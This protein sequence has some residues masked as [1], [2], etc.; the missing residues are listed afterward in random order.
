MRVYFFHKKVFFWEKTKRIIPPTSRP[1]ADPGDTPFPPLSPSESPSVT[2]GLH[3]FFYCFVI[4]VV[5]K[6]LRGTKTI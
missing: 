4:S 5:T 3:V 6:R 1:S 2:E